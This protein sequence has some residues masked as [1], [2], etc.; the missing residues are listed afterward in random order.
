MTIKRI[1]PYCKRKIDFTFTQNKFDFIVKEVPNRTFSNKGNYSILEIKKTYL[2]TWDLIKV[3]SDKL[4]IEEHKIGY[5]GLKDKN[6]TTTQF[7]SIPLT[8]EHLIKRLNSK[9]IEIINIFR[10]KSKLNI[11]DLKGN[12]FTI[13]LKNINHEDTSDLFQVLAKI[14][15]HGIPN[16]FGFQRFGKDFD[17][18]E[19]KAIAYGDNF[20]QNKKLS[21]ML[22]SAYQSYFFNNWLSERVTKSKNVGS[23]KLVE[24]EGDIFS[25][26][27]KYITGLLVG[28][29]IIRAKSKARTLE[30]KYDDEYVQL[31]G[32]RRDAWIDV[33]NLQSKYSKENKTLVLDFTLPKSSY[34]TVLIENLAMK[35]FSIN[36]TAKH[37][38]T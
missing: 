4:D 10:D 9:S 33:A 16:Y 7:I 13:T 22:T 31:K 27:S 30:E 3:I 18:E 19:A 12:K 21:H 34:A 25:K 5:A 35:N 6:A 26:T 37:Y 17:L 29:N 28:R 15:K 11:G 38:K 1:Y 32:M 24:I 20:I 23:N 8:K 36:E 14:Q 2:S